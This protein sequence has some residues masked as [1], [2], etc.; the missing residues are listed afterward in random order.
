MIESG[1]LVRGRLSKESVNAP[2][3]TAVP[4]LILNR[5]ITRITVIEVTSAIDGLNNTRTLPVIV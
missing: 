5:I 3:N 1:K 2:M 4:V